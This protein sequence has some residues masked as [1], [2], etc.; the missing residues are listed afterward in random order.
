MGADKV[1][2]RIDDAFGVDLYDYSDDP[3][4]W[5]DIRSYT[6][7]GRYVDVIYVGDKK[8]TGRAVREQALGLRSAAFE[9]DY[10]AGSD[11]FIFTTYGYG[12]GVGMSQTG[13]NL[14]ANEEG[15]DYIEILEHYY[16]GCRVR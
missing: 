10:D 3:N 12:H 1:A 13:A 5:F 7:G 15:W 8:T 6:E 11:E 4:D 9:I 2:D 16:P 14:Y